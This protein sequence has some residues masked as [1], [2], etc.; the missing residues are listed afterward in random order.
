ML[1]GRERLDLQYAGVA[2][3][4]TG[5]WVDRFSHVDVLARI[6][7]SRRHEGRRTRCIERD[8]SDRKETVF[9]KPYLIIVT[10]CQ[11]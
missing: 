10:V 3:S 7:V 8:D 6:D 4:A 1:V 9:L 5:S 11:Y 2:W